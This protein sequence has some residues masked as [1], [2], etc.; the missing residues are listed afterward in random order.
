LSLSSSSPAKRGTF[1]FSTQL[2]TSSKRSISGKEVDSF[3]AR[4]STC[5]P[6][7]ME[8]PV[9]LFGHD[10]CHGLFGKIPRS[11]YLGNFFNL[12]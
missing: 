12:S 2:A 3:D 1:G 11:L 6:P 9:S 10:F 5:A 7:Q 4:A 8:D